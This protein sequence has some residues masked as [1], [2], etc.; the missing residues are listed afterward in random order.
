[1]A[2]P[3][4]DGPRDFSDRRGAERRVRFT[5]WVDGYVQGVGFRAWVRMRAA[6]LGL[7]GSA[8]N[9]DDGRVE[10]IAEGSESECRRLLAALESGMTPGRVARVTKRWSEARGMRPGFGER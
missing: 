9:L 3:D 10:V 5:A 8:T 4:D 6:E 2:A 7:A 1:M